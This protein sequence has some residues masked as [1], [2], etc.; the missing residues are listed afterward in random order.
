MAE[1]ADPAL[2]RMKHVLFF[3]ESLSEGG[4]EK[5]LTTLLR[6]LD[7]AKYRI[8]LLTLVDAGVLRDEIDKGKIA[9]KTVIRP[10]SSPFGSLWSKFAYKLIYRY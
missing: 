9:Y 8:T 10:S 3:V 1:S 7:S 5:V 4:A 2:Y 6:H